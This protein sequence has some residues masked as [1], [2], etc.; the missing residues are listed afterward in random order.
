LIDRLVQHGWADRR[1]CTTDRRV[2]FCQISDSGLALLDSVDDMLAAAPSDFL[3][4]LTLAQ[5]EQLVSLLE[6]VRGGDSIP[7]C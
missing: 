4:R 7:A 3:K 1:R 6:L 5:Q 2:V